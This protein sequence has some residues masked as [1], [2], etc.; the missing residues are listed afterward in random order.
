MAKRVIDTTRRQILRGAAGFTLT[1]P[2]LPSLAEKS[3]FAGDALYVARPRLFW[4]GTDH[5]GA[6]EANMFPDASLLTNTMDLFPDHKVSSGALK[7]QVAGGRSTISP[8]LSASSSALTGKLLAKMNVLRGLDVPFYIGHSTGIHLG[9]YARNDGNGADGTAVQGTPRPTIDQIMAW[10]P[11]FYPDVAGI[12]E[13]AMLVNSGRTLS[14]NWSDP[15]SKTGSI[16]NVRALDSSRDLFNSIFVPASAGQ[17]K[18]PPI[19]DRVLASYKALRD[20]NKRISAADR[21]RL[22]DHIDRI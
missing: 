8:I 11:S 18:R 12:K 20:G 5:G 7:A 15:A 6:F 2:F 13:R 21:Q 9:N 3:A 16:Q 22:S 10:S 14:W 1:L 4:F 19:A 17:P